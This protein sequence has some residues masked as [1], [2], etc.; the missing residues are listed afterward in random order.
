M[1][2]PGD[3]QKIISKHPCWVRIGHSS[4]KPQRHTETPS[5]VVIRWNNGRLYPQREVTQTRS[6]GVEIGSVLVWLHYR[7]YLNPIPS[8]TLFAERSSKLEIY[9]IKSLTQNKVLLFLVL[10]GKSSDTKLRKH[11]HQHRV[12]AVEFAVPEDQP[13]GAELQGQSGGR[14]DPQPF[15][16]LLWWMSASYSH[17]RTHG[18]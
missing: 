3:L 9:Q 18:L 2:F 15:D 1:S 7:C 11:G 16:T 13:D 6:A 8:W 12:R 14:E 17:L 10:V 4:N 5:V